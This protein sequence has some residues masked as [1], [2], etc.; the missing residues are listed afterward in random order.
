VVQPENGTEYA[1]RTKECPY[2]IK[3]GD[4]CWSAFTKRGFSWGGAWNNHKDYQHFEIKR[5][6]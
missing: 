2:Y 4:I 6:E 1:D 5:V 3:K